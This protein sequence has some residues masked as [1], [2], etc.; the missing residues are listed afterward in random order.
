MLNTQVTQQYRNRYEKIVKIENVNHLRSTVK[1]AARFAV[2]DEMIINVKNHQM[3]PTI[4]VDV[5][6][7][8]MR[9]KTEFFQLIFPNKSN[10]RANN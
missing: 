8:K 2:Y 6:Y 5:A 1:N 3:P 9:K 10:M 7:S 4:R